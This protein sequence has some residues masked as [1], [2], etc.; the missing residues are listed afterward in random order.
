MYKVLLIYC[1]GCLLLDK[2]KVLL[3]VYF[4]YSIFWIVY[5]WVY[6]IGML[7][8]GIYVNMVDG[9]NI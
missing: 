8:S 5:W 9:C 6:S 7:S 3:S 1:F 4:C 2:Y